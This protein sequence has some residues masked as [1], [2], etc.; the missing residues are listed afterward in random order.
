MKDYAN[1]RLKLKRTVIWA[2]CL[3]KFGL[4]L[5]VKVGLLKA[6]TLFAEGKGFFAFFSDEAMFDP[7]SLVD[8]RRGDSTPHCWRFPKLRTLSLQST[9]PFFL[10]GIKVGNLDR[11]RW[12]DH[13]CLISQLEH[14]ICF[15]SLTVAASYIVT[16]WFSWLNQKGKN[17]KFWTPSRMK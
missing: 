7:W 6:K 5:K 13:A 11:E 10:R 8:H 12:A 3:H 15:I 2:F 4:Y 9:K 14:R 17:D 1:L 16:K